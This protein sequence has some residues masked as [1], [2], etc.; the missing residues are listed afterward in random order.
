[1][2]NELSGQLEEQLDVDRALAAR[3]AEL[4]EVESGL[5]VSEGQR[6]IAEKL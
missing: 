2:Q 4:E 1:M 3:R 5:R 6:G